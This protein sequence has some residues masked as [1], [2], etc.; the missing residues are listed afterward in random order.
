MHGECLRIMVCVSVS[1]SVFKMRE[2][3]QA[4]VCVDAHICMRVFA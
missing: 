1:L 3:V 2:L 4:C